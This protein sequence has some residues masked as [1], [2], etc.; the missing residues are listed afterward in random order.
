ML[1]A[2]VVAH[3]IMDREVMDLIPAGSLAFFSSLS[4]QKCVRNQVPRGGA[5]LLV[6]I[7]QKM[8]SCAATRTSL[9][10]QV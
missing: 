7:F 5:S 1:V 6:F 4:Y 10:L 2:Q 3:R 9:I 8:L